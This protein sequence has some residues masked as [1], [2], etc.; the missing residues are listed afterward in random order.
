MELETVKA[1]IEL[2][3]KAGLTELEIQEEGRRVRLAKAGPPAGR[4]PLTAESTDGR[5]S[6]DDTEG[7]Y[8][9][10]TAQPETLLLRSPMVGTFYRAPSPNSRPFV[11]K[12]QLV[13]VGEVVAIVEAM[14]MMNKIESTVSGVIDEIL[15]ENGEAVEFD[16]PLFRLFKE[17]KTSL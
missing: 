5:T 13:Q 10:F 2:M 7:A 1:L 11:A 3:E 4:R 15:V 8:A 16:Q 17:D 9:D 14:K 12:S 6:T